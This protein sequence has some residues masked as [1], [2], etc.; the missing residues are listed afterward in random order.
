[1]NN[2]LPI[3]AVVAIFLFVVKEI[4]EFCR[5]SIE[6]GRKRSAI[7]ELISH[8]VAANYRAFGYLYSAIRI[9]DE[10][11]TPG[12]KDT[13]VVQH[14]GRLLFERTHPSQIGTGNPVPSPSMTEFNRLLPTVAEI[15]KKLYAAIREGYAAIYQ[16][17][18]LHH[19]FVDYVLGGE[20][21]KEI[22]G[23]FRQY[24]WASF[25]ETEKGIWELYVFL[26]GRELP[27]ERA[28]GARSPAPAEDVVSQDRAQKP[29]VSRRRKQSEE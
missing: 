15:D 11:I 3:A 1:M 7:K 5:R 13:I 12:E 28:V 18:H 21:E 29:R 6:R 22:F 10:K 9:T 14:G 16:L 25:D 8:E 27:I 19:S 17:E 2:L 4:F 20:K 26:T 23:G 24:A